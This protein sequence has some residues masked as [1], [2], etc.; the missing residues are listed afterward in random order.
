MN[1]VGKSIKKYREGKGVTQEQM[2][3]AL[4]VTRQA[5]SNWERGKSEPD[6]DTLQKISDYFGIAMEELIYGEK[7]EIQIA[8][9]ASANISVGGIGF[10]TILAMI[11]SYVKWH[12]IG[13]AIVHGA[14]N[15]IYVIYFII[16]YGWNG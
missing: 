5:I 11:I 15:W 12:S 4:S 8:K 10:G 7:K 16:K 14:L 13:W 3:E 9:K 2:A 6:I 1:T